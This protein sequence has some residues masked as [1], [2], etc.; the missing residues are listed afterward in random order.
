MAP[1]GVPGAPGLHRCPGTSGT[2]R[3][4]RLLLRVPTLP[5]GAA[6][7]CGCAS[8]ALANYS[9][10]PLIPH[11]IMFCTDSPLCSSQLLH[12]LLLVTFWQGEESSKRLLTRLFSV[13]AWDNRVGPQAGGRRPAWQ[14]CGIPLPLQHPA[15]THLAEQHGR[16]GF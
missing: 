6:P 7:M 9:C 15:E 12:D 1:R 3:T 14:L 8:Q 13:A 10:Q 16:L 11:K 5:L 4:L 2:T